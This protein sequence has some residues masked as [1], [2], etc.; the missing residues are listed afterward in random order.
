MDHDNDG[1]H[2]TPRHV[3]RLP[4]CLPPYLD[5]SY[6]NGH[7]LWKQWWQQQKGEEDMFSILILFYFTIQ[8]IIYIIAATMRIV[9]ATHTHHQNR[10]R[11]FS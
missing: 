4:K 6:Y 8:V 3:R 1:C 7:T 2:I 10:I 9:H 5:S 11:Y